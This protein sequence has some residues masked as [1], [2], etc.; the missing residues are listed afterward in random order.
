MKVKSGLKEE[1]KKNQPNRGR[2]DCP[3]LFH[4]QEHQS[5]VEI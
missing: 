2:R 1:L 3:V 5:G 4:K